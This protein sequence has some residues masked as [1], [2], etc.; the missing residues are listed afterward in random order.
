MARWHRVC[1]HMTTLAAV[2]AFLANPAIAVA[3]VS[4]SSR[5]FGNMALKEL[6]AKGYRVYPVHPSAERID[7]VRCFRRFADLP[8]P[9]DAVLVVVPPAAA[10]DVVREAAAAGLH[11]V[12]LQ[13]G[14]ESEKVLSL[15]REL[16]LVAIARECILMFAQ[17][18]SYH[19][20]HRWIWG[21]LGR[22]PS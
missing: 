5:K 4:R 20:V 17:P 13:Q 10:L 16:G 7:G 19:R 3:G 14:A 21:A 12:W 22:L 9:V 18:T 11:Y 15:C 8:E 6:G 1:F 2:N